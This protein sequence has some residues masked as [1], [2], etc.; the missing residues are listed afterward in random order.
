MFVSVIVCSFSSFSKISIFVHLSPVFDKLFTS[1]IGKLLN[2]ETCFTTENCI[3]Q[4]GIKEIFTPHANLSGMVQMKNLDLH[5]STVL[6][7]AIIDVNEE[8]TV[9]SAA[10][11]KKNLDLQISTVLHKA[12]I[13]VNEEGTVASAATGKVYK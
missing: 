7:K 6:H 2:L 13:D 8:G 1:E 3:L 10:T 5:I 4:L 12:I 9:A 11:G